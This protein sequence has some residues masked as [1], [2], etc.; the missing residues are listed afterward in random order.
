MDWYLV[1]RIL[2][3]IGWPL[4]AAALVYAV[5]WL[6][7]ALRPPQ[8]GSPRRAWINICAGMAYL[9]TLFATGLHLLRY[10]RLIG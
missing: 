2:G 1:G 4:A 10:L 8:P 6:I 3:V 7:A 9:V 5:G